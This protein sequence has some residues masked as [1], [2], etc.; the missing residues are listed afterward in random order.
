MVIPRVMLHSTS[1]GKQ[2]PTQKII[3]DTKS[4]KGS[5][6]EDKAGYIVCILL[7]TIVNKY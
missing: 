2:K 6:I 7:T 5:G 4:D 3:S 1:G